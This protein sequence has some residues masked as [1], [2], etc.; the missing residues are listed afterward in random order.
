LCDEDNTGGFI[1]ATMTHSE[2]LI[3]RWTSKTSRAPGEPWS[4]DL[5]IDD[6]TPAEMRTSEPTLAAGLISGDV[7]QVTPSG[8]Y[9]SQDVSR[10][11]TGGER[12]VHASILEAIIAHVIYHPSTGWRLL[13]AYVIDGK[14]QITVGAP[15]PLEGEP[16]VI[17][18]L[19]L[20]YGTLL[21]SNVSV[22]G[23][24]TYFC[25]VAFRTPRKVAIF[26][27][28]PGISEPVGQLEMDK[29]ISVGDE[30]QTSDIHSI[31]S[32]QTRG[33]GTSNTFI[34]FG[35]R[36]GLMMSCRL[37]I[38]NSNQQGGMFLELKTTKFGNTQVE[39]LSVTRDVKDKRSVFLSCGHVWEITA[40]GVGLDVNE[41]LFDDFRMVSFSWWLTVAKDI[42]RKSFC[43]TQR[44]GSFDGGVNSIRGCRHTGRSLAEDDYNRTGT[45]SQVPL[46]KTPRRLHYDT[47]MQR[48]VIGCGN[49]VR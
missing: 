38:G 27:V 35:M 31:E 17:K 40:N 29:F 16:S 46:M 21:H 43:R 14:K 1:V 3:L 30:P 39:F 41:V 11:Y 33:E 26:P 28:Q 12:I 2:T 4:G 20:L 19:T 45:S 48:M 5:D 10:Q 13:Y 32:L 24:K 18:L 7:I 44:V 6:V 36:H 9:L 37:S 25:L 49:A 47:K 42:I 22:N 15:I 8:V 34:L 23:A